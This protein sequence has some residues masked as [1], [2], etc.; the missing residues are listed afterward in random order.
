[1]YPAENKRSQTPEPARLR[2]AHVLFLDIIGYSLL[3]TDEQNLTVQQL[4]DIVRGLSGFEESLSSDELICTPTGD[5]MAIVCFGEPT[6]PVRFARDLAIRV[7]KEAAFALRIGLNSGPVYCTADIN[8]Q[9]NV[10]GAGVN[11]AQRIM[12]CGD[13]GH[14]LL[15]QSVADTLQ[16]LSEWR[17]AVHDLGEC[18]V[19]HG[20]RLRVF[21][22]FNSEFGNR[23]LPKRMQYG[24]IDPD[25]RELR[26]V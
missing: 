26:S 10:A 13:G 16:Q 18:E 17:E 5:G 20:V 21:N 15:S 3:A 23:A 11:V 19:K 4:Q 6:L 24:A 1:M 8:R 14:I 12:D 2:T 9:H 7:P 25:A 22:L